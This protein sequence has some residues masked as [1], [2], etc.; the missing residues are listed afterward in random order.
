MSWPSWTEKRCRETSLRE[1]SLG[2]SSANG[3]NSVLI[4][5]ASKAASCWIR[6]LDYFDLSLAF[7]SLRKIVKFGFRRTVEALLACGLLLQRYISLDSPNKT[8]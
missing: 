1:R 7:N 4:W 8:T 2:I 6:S 3:C 5:P